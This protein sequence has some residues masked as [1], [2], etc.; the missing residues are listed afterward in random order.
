MTFSDFI[1]SVAVPPAHFIEGITISIGVVILLAL[2]AL[3]SGKRKHE[4]LISLKTRAVRF[5]ATAAF[6]LGYWVYITLASALFSGVVDFQI[7][8]AFLLYV[9]LTVTVIIG[10]YGILLAGLYFL[11][12]RTYVFFENRGVVKNDKMPSIIGWIVICTWIFSFVSFLFGLIV[13][14]TSVAHANEISR[15]SSAAV[16]LFAVIGAALIGSARG[17]WGRLLER[18]SGFF[19]RAT[20]AK[21]T[22]TTRTRKV[23]KRNKK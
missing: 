17:V 5:A 15:F 2:A 10:V 12:L 6:L 22:Y 4:V 9:M 13:H 7:N 21:E 19:R 11:F 3:G 18:G 14:I 8:V 16:V 20:A 23:R 1:I